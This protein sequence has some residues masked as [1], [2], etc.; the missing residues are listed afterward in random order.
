MKKHDPKKTK[1]VK[2]LPEKKPKKGYLCLSPLQVQTLG[3]PV[4][5][6]KTMMAILGV[7]S[8]KEEALKYGKEFLEVSL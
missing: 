8:S 6:P 5:M 1:T 2:A 4:E 3:L 7:F